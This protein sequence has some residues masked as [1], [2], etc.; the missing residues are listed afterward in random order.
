MRQA[1]AIILGDGGLDTLEAKLR[2]EQ[3]RRTL[4]SGLGME[5]VATKV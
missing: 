4:N 1:D 5:S 3:I 2:G